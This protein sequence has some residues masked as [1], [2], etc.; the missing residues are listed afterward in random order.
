MED[1]KD[2]RRLFYDENEVVS[3]KYLSD[4]D[5]SRYLITKY[6]EQNILEK[7]GYGKYRLN[8][9]APDEFYSIQ[10]RSSKIV[11]SHASALY[12]ANFTDKIPLTYDITVPQ[13]YNVSKI[14]RDFPNIN[15]YYSK[16][17]LWSV[18]LKKTV[19]PFG[20]EVNVYDTERTVLDIIKKRKKIDYQVYIQFLKD[21]FK[22]NT[23]FRKILKYAKLMNMEQKIR[24][25]IE[26]LQQ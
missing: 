14:K 3:A 17:D 7:A 12:L 8:N 13:G 21:Y 24:D 15:F 26:L 22:S 10:T 25:Y 19:T 1:V 16:T 11:F 5:V 2:I 6:L 23:N 4:N 20:L 18:G 9:A